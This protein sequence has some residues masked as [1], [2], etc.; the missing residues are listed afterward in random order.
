MPELEVV[1]NARPS[2]F[3]YPAKLEEKKDKTRE[4][5]ETAVLSITAK[6]KKKK[7]DKS[8]PASTQSTADTTSSSTAV[9]SNKSE[10]MD[11]SSSTATTEKVCDSDSSWCVSF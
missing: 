11:T 7:G 6:Q 3:G 9:D 5:V 1:S 2:L 8:T 10:K 4:K